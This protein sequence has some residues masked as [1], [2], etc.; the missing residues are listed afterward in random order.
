M[1]TNIHVLPAKVRHTNGSPEARRLRAAGSLPA[2]AYGKDLAA[3]AVA[4][5]PKEV[6]KILSSERGKNTVVKLE[7]E[8]KS[9]ILAMV[10]SFQ[11]HPL[12]RQI[13][14]VDFIEVKLDREVDA[15]I[16]LVTTGK[17]VGVVKG[18]V[19]RQVFRTLPVRCTPDLIPLRVTYDVSAL[20]LSAHVAAKDFDL[21]AGVTIRLPPEQTVIHVAAPEADTDADAAPVAGAAAPA[22]KDAKAGAKG[23]PAAKA[24]PAAKAPAKKK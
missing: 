12:S 13:E 14:H 23:A 20:E 5:D 21:G 8:G 24:S 9:D 17:C 10:R 19:L 11:I 1:S 7:V 16:L 22:G 15:E 2:V 3:L 4:V 18:G 6:H